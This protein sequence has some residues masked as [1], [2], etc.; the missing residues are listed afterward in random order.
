MHGGS[1][2]GLRTLLAFRP[3]H[4]SIVTTVGAQLRFND[5][6]IDPRRGLWVIQWLRVHLRLLVTVGQWCG[7]CEQEKDPVCGQSLLRLLCLGS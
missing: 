5:Q 7:E 4:W 3:S 6:F 2:G 1:W